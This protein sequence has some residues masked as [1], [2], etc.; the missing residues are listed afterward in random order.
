MNRYVCSQIARGRARTVV[1]DHQ[2]GLHTSKKVT[3]SLILFNCDESE[4]NDRRSSGE[5]IAC[6]LQIGQ[7]DVDRVKRQFVEVDL[8]IALGGRQGQREIYERK[9]DGDF[10]VHLITLSCSDLPPGFVQRS[11]RLRSDLVAW[12]STIMNIAVSETATSIQFFRNDF[13]AHILGI[14]SLCS[15]L[16]SRLLHEFQNQTLSVQLLL[17]H[18]MHSQNRWYWRCSTT[19]APIDHS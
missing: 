12:R 6:V 9:A 8:D 15:L 13:I 4:C 7:G 14:H 17:F 2:K 3:H 10:E 18:S 11:L 16:P 1:G 5:T 19:Y